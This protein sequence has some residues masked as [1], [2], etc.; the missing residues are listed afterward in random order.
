MWVIER[1]VEEESEK[2]DGKESKEEEGDLQRNVECLK[3]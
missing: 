2:K 3:V 1:D